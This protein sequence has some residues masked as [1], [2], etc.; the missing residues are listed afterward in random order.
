LSIQSLLATIAVAIATV[1]LLRAR[2]M[3]KQLARLTESYWELRYDY[4]QLRARVQRLDPDAP[5][6]PDTPAQPPAPATFVPLS[7]LKR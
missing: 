2:R 4:G 7:S 1:A 6:V 3:S 5:P